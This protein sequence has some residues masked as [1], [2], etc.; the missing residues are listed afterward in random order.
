MVLNKF[1]FPDSDAPAIITPEGSVSYREL[2]ERFS[3]IADSLVKRGVQPGD[4]VAIQSPNSLEVLLLL[5]ALW[6]VGAVAFPFSERFPMKEIL[7]LAE[8]YRCK[9]FLPASQL[10]E[11]SAN[12][13]LSVIPLSEATAF[14][15]EIKSGISPVW[16]L[17]NLASIILTSGSSGNP[18][19][20]VHSLANHY[21]SAIGS[22]ENI[23][24]GRGGRW[25]L[26]L[27][28]YHVGGL[29]ILFRA[30][31]AEGAIALPHPEMPLQDAIEQLQPSHISLVATQ[32]YR[33]LKTADG[34]RA[35]RRMKAVLLGGSAIPENLLREAWTL[36]IPVHTSYGS[37]EMSSQ[38]TTT[39]AN[40]S[41][42]ELQTSGRL[43]PHREI[44]TA[45][46]GEILVCGKTLFQGYLEDDKVVP[47]V[48][49]DGWFGS[50]DIGQ[51]D[52]QGNLTV[53]GR[54]D[55][56]FISGGENIQPEEIEKHLSHIEGV[57]RCM[58]VPVI[59]Q[60]FGMR[61]V[62]FIDMRNGGKLDTS[63]LRLQL[64]K[65]LPRFKVPDKFLPWP[66][67]SQSPGIKADRQALAKIA[68]AG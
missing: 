52:A 48:D 54:K 12:T 8:K 16:Q 37:S 41:L 64:E 35:L 53:T 50:G 42:K 65:N 45:G 25:L 59:H 43:L 20:V 19:A 6:S 3:W 57:I 31:T 7:T 62:A 2:N 38:I 1:Q 28:L 4:R 5:P 46:D 58:V 68:A 27:P 63:A 56:M 17:D 14:P 39:P 36:E 29:A 24:F 47:S 13:K 23:P 18:K 66:K 49:E 51:M 44:M 10:T 15:A 11:R 9:Y 21:Y 26:S 67:D 33:L 60:E 40:A 22:H 61:P 30:W 32:L 55:N 34:R